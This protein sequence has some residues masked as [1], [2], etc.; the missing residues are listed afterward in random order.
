M[1]GHT[2]TIQGLDR[3][4]ERHVAVH[5]VPKVPLVLQDQMRMV[6]LALQVN[7]SYARLPRVMKYSFFSQAARGRLLKWS[8]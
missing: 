3:L 6:L 4:A 5:A 8:A 7:S 2:L 1:A